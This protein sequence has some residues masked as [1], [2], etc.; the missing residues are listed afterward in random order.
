MVDQ[1]MYGSSTPLVNTTDGVQLQIKRKT[2]GSGDV[3]C[4]EFMTS[5]FQ[6]NIIDRK[7][8]SVQF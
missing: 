5:Y 4:H 2:T 8:K 7:L 1:T 6:F 3:N